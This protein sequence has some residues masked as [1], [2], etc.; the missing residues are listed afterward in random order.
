MQGD[1]GRSIPPWTLLILAAGVGRRFGGDKQLQQVGPGG[2]TLADYS[3]WDA[4]RAGATSIVVVTRQ[5]LQEEFS[6]RT[7]RW[8]GRLAARVVVQR[9]D[10]VPG[11][12]VPKGRQVPWGTLHAA[13]AARAAIPGPFVVVNADDFYGP[14]AFTLCAEFLRDAPAGSP[15]FAAVGYELTATLSAHGGVSRALLLHGDD[16]RLA[17][18]VEVAEVAATARGITG[19]SG[20]GEVRLSG[21]ALV[22][23][24]CWALTP[25]MLPALFDELV[26][27][28]EAHG[29]SLDAEARLPDALHRLV[30]EGRAEGRVLP[31]GGGWLGMTHPADRE[32]VAAGL[33]ARVARGDYPAD[34]FAVPSAP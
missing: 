14:R 11:G 5:E 9:L 4:W 10:D 32:P 22:S 18:I 19:R 1:A 21:T 34:L 26:R 23:M 15:S 20:G 31:G 16:A 17:G 2:E 7:R 25:G 27:F 13:L 12:T 33:R 29:E 6:A 30:V 28:L 24:N 8:A 3:I